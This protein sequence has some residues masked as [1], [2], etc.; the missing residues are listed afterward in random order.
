MYL[1]DSPINVSGPMEKCIGTKDN[2]DVRNIYI[3]ELPLWSQKQRIKW[4]CK[5]LEN[6]PH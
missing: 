6:T 3:G 1:G 4:Q 5:K 2:S